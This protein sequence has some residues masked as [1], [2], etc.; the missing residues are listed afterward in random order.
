MAIKTHKTGIHE[1][2]LVKRSLKLQSVKESETK[3]IV[4]QLMELAEVDDAFFSFNKTICILNISYDASIKTG[5]LKEIKAVL[6][7]FDTFITNDWWTRNKVSYYEFL[8]QNIFDNAR[9]VPACC[10]K[11]PPGK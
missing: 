5:P 6:S 2:Y 1:N 4:E 10:S 7:H 9:H 3:Q 11:P 8:D